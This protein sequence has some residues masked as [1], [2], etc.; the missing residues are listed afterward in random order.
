MKNQIII[1]TIICLVVY[2]CKG[3]TKPDL[4]VDTNSAKTK[5][6][7]YTVF[8]T[9]PDNENIF[10]GYDAARQL[11]NDWNNAIND[12]NFIELEKLYHDALN[13]HETNISLHDRMQLQKKDYKLNPGHK[14]SIGRVEI[15]NLDED[16]MPLRITAEFDLIIRNKN[17]KDT[18]ISFLTFEKIK[19]DWKIVG[20]TDVRSIEFEAMNKPILN[21]NKGEYT[22]ARGYWLDTRDVPDFGHDQVPYSFIISISITDSITGY[23]GFYSGMLREN[24]EYLIP[25]GNISDGILNLT[26]IWNGNGESSLEEYYEGNISPDK[27]EQWRFKIIS[28]NELYGID[29]NSYL[30]GYSLHYQ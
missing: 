22:F 26:T 11:L 5:D 4:T 10:R 24:T 15:Y 9:P 18:I 12:N 21:L 8:T 16:T 2:S 17:F 30:Q 27:I 7:L 1:I 20:E 6:T 19:D 3:K 23:A 25:E 14:Q 28:W 29:C 13:Y